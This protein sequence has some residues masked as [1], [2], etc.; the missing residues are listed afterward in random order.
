MGDAIEATRVEAPVFI[1]GHYRSGTT[2]LHELLSNDPGFASPNRFQAF[3][4]STFLCH[5]ADG[6]LPL[7][8]PFM[9]PS[10]GA[11]G[12]DRVH[13]PDATVALHGLVL[14]A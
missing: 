10:P 6:R 4:P 11:G 1:L 8:E 7:I 13:G 12:R 2:Y 9:L 3:N 5:R 14:P